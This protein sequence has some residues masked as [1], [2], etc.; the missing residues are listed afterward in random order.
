MNSMVPVF[1]T[2]TAVVTSALLNRNVGDASAL[3]STSRLLTD[4]MPVATTVYVPSASMTAFCVAVGTAPPSHFVGSFQLPFPPSQCTVVSCTVNVTRTVEVRFADTAVTPLGKPVVTV[5]ANEPD[6]AAN[7]TTS[8]VAPEPG[9]KSSN[10]E[11]SSVPARVA[12]PVTDSTS[13]S[14]AGVVPP[15]LIRNTPSANCV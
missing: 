15:R 11:S 12:V 14:V 2:N 10:G 5:E 1:R 4:M 13:N 8:N 7:A 9:R 6:R 3:A